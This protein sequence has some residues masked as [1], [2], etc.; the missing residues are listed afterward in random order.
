MRSFNP[1]NDYMF[2]SYMANEGIKNQ[3]KSFINTVVLEDND[4]IN[5]IDIVAN[6]L[7]TGE[8]KGKKTFILD[9]RSESLMADTS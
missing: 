6:K 3:F 2:S 7:I 8:I 4:S 9:L 1:L 5:S